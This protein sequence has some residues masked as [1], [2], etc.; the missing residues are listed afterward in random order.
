MEFICD[1]AA[2]MTYANDPHARHPAIVLGA[3][4]NRYV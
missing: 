3:P 4:K 2:E 1:L